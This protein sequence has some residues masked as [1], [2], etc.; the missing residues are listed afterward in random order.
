MFHELS[1]NRCYGRSMQNDPF[2]FVRTVFAGLFVLTLL[3]GGYLAK[4]Y[5]KLFGADSSMPSE[6]ESARAYSKVQ[7][8][9]IWAHAVVLTG[10]F[11]LMIH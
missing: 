1:A 4:N 11:A 2:L 7:V 6:N 10:A 3:S 5:G 8:F 9:L